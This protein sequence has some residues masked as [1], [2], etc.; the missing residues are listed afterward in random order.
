M[1]HTHTETFNATAPIK[2]DSVKIKWL[3]DSDPDLSWLDQYE[4]SQDP[5]EKEYYKRDQERKAS[6]GN[7]WEMLGCVAEAQVSRPIGQGSRR[8]E[9]LTSGGLW[10]IESDSDRDYMKQ[11]EHEQLSDLAEHLNAFGIEVTAEE[12][13][14]LNQSHR[15]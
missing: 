5:E 1:K 12:L 2:V 13:H 3:H 9:T 4:D 6:Y 11:V 10:G 7:Q 14:H 8:L 15:T